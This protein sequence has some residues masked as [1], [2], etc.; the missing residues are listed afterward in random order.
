MHF[1][2]LLYSAFRKLRGSVDA[3]LALFTANKYDKRREAGSWGSVGA[4]GSKEHGH[5]H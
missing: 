1:T 3:T 5:I 2:R 4:M